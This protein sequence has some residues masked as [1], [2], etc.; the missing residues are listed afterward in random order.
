METSHLLDRA[1]GAASRIPWESPEE[2]AEALGETMWI[3]EW[4]IAWAGLYPARWHRKEIRGED[5]PYNERL[6]AA[7]EALK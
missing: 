7:R 6:A 5:Y 4:P 1:Y 3:A 2:L